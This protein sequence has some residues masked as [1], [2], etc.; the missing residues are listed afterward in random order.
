MPQRQVSPR[1]GDHIHASFPELHNIPEP[2]RAAVDNFL[3][4]RVRV[5][6]AQDAYREAHL[7]LGDAKQKEDQRLKQHIIDGG[8]TATFERTATREGQAAIDNAHQDYQVLKELIAPAYLQAMNALESVALDG[9]AHAQQEVE[10]TAPAYL[11]AIE[12][13]ERA[14]RDYLN[15]VGLRYFWAFLT[16]QH[17]AVAGAGMSDV[18]ILR[19]GPITRVDDGVFAML[20]SDAKTHTR[21]DGTSTATSSW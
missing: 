10:A 8:T 4:M 2:A 18:I 20:R 9:A 11:A 7:A 21:I 14:R 15:A 16:E 1:K 17:Q 6:E 5:A 19:E 13:A 12:A 3:N